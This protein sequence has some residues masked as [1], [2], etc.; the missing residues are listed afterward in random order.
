MSRSEAF[1]WQCAVFAYFFKGSLNV[2]KPLGRGTR[3]GILGKCSPLDITDDVEMGREV[4]GRLS[5]PY[6]SLFWP[7]CPGNLIGRGPMSEN[8]GHTHY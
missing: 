2:V 7:P 6:S 1:Q 5:L 8:I 3:K 4:V